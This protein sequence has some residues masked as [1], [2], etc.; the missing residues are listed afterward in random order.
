MDHWLNSLSTWLA[1]NPGWLTATVAGTAFLESL[2]IAGLVVPGVAI[3]FVAATAAGHL[4]VSVWSVIAWACLGAIIGDGISFWIGRRLQSNVSV[5][6]PFSEFPAALDR[7]ERFFHQHDGKS[8]V[9]GRFIGPIRPIIPLVAGAFGMPVKRFLGFNIVSALGWA[10]VYVL[11]GFLVGTS[12]ADETNLPPH[13]YPVLIFSALA[14]TV[15]LGV[16]FRI[17][18]GLQPERGIYRQAQH[19]LQRR[20]LTQQ[21]WNGLI[22][23]RGK[24]DEFP[25]ASLVLAAGAL[26]LFAGWTTAAIHA[27]LLTSL[28]TQAL[29]FFQALRHPLLDPILLTITLSGSL[30]LLGAGFL[31]FSLL[32]Y[33]SDHKAA[34]LHVMGAAAATALMTVGLQYGLF[35]MYPGEVDISPVT[36]GYPS[37]HSSGATVFY[38]IA[39][40][41]IAQEWQHDKRWKAYGLAIVPILL[42]PLS[43]LYLGV[44]GFADAIGGILLGLAVCGTVRCSFSRYDRFRLHLGKSAALMLLVWPGLIALY[45]AIYWQKAT[46]SYAFTTLPG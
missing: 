35:I 36:F 11:P 15:L 3:L 32:L 8:I 38:G 2:A 6:W 17:H 25:L 28:D 12:L 40:A 33:V 10:P 4:G 26:V 18:L 44:G 39:A 7:G 31:L 5:I 22:R 16:L 43:R 42:L 9:L 27:D 37:L 20:A 23:P 24:H 41:F 45:V 46:E 13:V 19:L 21:F 30:V 14:V 34:A 29:Q 1:A